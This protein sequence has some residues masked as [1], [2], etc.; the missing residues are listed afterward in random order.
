MFDR[1]L[2]MCL[3]FWICLWSWVC[4]GFKYTMVL[5]MPL[6]PNLLGF[7]TRVLDIPLVL[8]KSR[9]W[10]WQG[11][12]WF[13]I[14]LNMPTYAGIYVRMPK[15]AWLADCLICFI[16]SHFNSLSAW[17]RR[18]LI[19]HLHEARS[20]ILKGH[21][22]VFLKR[23]NQIFSRVTSKIWEIGFGKTRPY[24]FYEVFY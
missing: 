9:F 15:S 13:G 10:I 11:R 20:Y 12:I 18:Y 23:Q 7:D 16:F 17:T 1:V 8:N 3:G 6:V 5:K 19:Q 4:Q 22:A 2:W 21:V 24:I 14:C